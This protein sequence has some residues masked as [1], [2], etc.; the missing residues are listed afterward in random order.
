MTTVTLTS[1]AGRTP[2]LPVPDRVAFTIPENIPLIGGLDI[3][4]YGIMLTLGIVAAFLVVYKKAPSRC[5]DP[6]KTLDY[7]LW[8]VPFGVVGARL[9]YVIFE[10]ENYKDDLRS[11]LNIREGGLAIHGA[12]IAGITVGIICL[13]KWKQKILDWVDLTFMGVVIGQAI[14]RWGNYFNSEAHGT[15]TDLPWAIYCD[16]EFVHPTFLYE[17]IWCFLL[18]L[19]LLWFDKKKAKY[20]GQITCL[21]WILYSV[22]R[23]F[24]EGLR[25]DSL[26]IGSFR[27][28]QVISVV[29]IVLGIIG[30][31]L[32]NKNKDK[33]V[34]TRPEKKTDKE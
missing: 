17:S 27:Q 11:I 25:T 1:A 23:F 30:L 10:W 21:Y 15:A 16:G 26:W 12:L 28:A 18:F 7:A 22:E 9:Y 29:S 14:G 6:E 19:F 8:I 3:M 33:L 13:I 5:I 2:F 4:W 32:I 31:I 20:R 24:V 34:I